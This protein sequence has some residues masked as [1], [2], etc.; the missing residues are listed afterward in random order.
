MTSVSRAQRK[1][2]GLALAA[3]RGEVSPGI[4]RGAALQMYSSMTV[5]QLEDFA[6]TKEKGLPKRK[7]RGKK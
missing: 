6:E 5:R 1:A 2:A 4:L 7:S 3:K